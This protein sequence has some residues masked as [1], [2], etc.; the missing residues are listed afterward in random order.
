MQGSRLDPTPPHHMPLL[1]ESIQSCTVSASRII[2][3]QTYNKKEKEKEKSDLF[4]TFFNPPYS[5]H[6]SRLFLFHLSD[7]PTVTTPHTVTR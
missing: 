2:N 7:T 6:Y 3:K 5:I 4:F 1:K